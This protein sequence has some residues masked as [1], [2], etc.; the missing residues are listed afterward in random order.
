MM[1]VTFLG[2]GTSQGIPVIGCACEV[3]QSSDSRDKRLRTSVMIETK[4]KIIVIDTGPDFRQQMLRE[5][6][7]HDLDKFCVDAVLFTHEHKDHIAGLDDVRPFNFRF[8]RDMQVYATTHVQE[9]LMR[10]YQYVFTPPF[11]P[12]APLIQLNTIPEDEKFTIE[13]ID[14]QPIQI[15]HG[16]LPIL[17]FRFGDFT[18]LTDV[19]TIFPQEKEK[20]YGTKTLVLSALRKEEHHSH[21]TLEEALALV[22]EFQPKQTY[23]IHMSH[24]L[25]K[26]ED[27]NDKLPKNVQLAYDGLKIILN[28]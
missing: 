8:R 3:C 11:Y 21:L 5:Q 12:G 13:G 25:G 1:K 4:G 18:Y 6:V 20:I 15:M 17:G 10:E 14:I 16:T 22:E 23:F 7:Y 24:L 28:E 9:A 2:T 27:I 19:K 26:H